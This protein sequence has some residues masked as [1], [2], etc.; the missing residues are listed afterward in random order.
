MK[1]ISIF[2][3]R[4]SLL[5]TKWAVIGTLWLASVFLVTSS[6]LLMDQFSDWARMLGGYT[7]PYSK[8]KATVRSQH[9]KLKAQKTRLDN[10]RRYV[11]RHSRK[12]KMLGGKM[13]ARNVADATTSIIPVIGGA[14]SVSFAVWDVYAAC[15]L[16]STQKEFELLMGTSTADDYSALES[17]CVTATTSVESAS[18]SATETLERAS[19]SAEEAFSS[20]KSNTASVHD[21]WATKACEWTEKCS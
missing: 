18:A 21:W 1:L 19:T 14:A 15:E 8:Q 6:A 12:V 2:F 9:A 10:Q 7:T 20:L 11:K 4:L 5:L 17:T 13:I 16:I 3:A